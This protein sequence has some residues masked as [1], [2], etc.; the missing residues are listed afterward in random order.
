MNPQEEFGK[1]LEAD[2]EGKLDADGRQRLESLC[3]TR[4]ELR[5]R[6]DGE[7]EITR[8]LQQMGPSH[9]PDFLAAKVM[10]RLEDDAPSA[11]NIIDPGKDH[12]VDRVKAIL[13]RP[14]RQSRK[15]FIPLIQW[16]A[17]A[18][19]LTFIFIHGS[20]I[21]HEDSL[22][23]QI[24]APQGDPVG[25]RTQVDPVHSAADEAGGRINHLR[26][27][28]SGANALVAEQPADDAVRRDEFTEKADQKMIG[29]KGRIDSR[30]DV[31]H[32][33][34]VPMGPGEPKQQIP[35]VVPFME[36]SQV[37]NVSEDADPGVRET[38]TALSGAREPVKRLGRGT[39]GGD[40]TNEIV[41]TREQPE[42][43]E[44]RLM[45]AMETA[46]ETKPEPELGDA[47]HRTNEL[48]LYVFNFNVIPMAESK[49]EGQPDRSASLNKRKIPS[50]TGARE[51]SN[52]P[53]V[54]SF[55]GSGGGRKSNVKKSQPMKKPVAQAEA[56]THSRGSALQNI[57][58]LVSRHSGEIESIEM[59]VEKARKVWQLDL[60]MTV[61]NLAALVADL[62]KQGVPPRPAFRV[63]LESGSEEKTRNEMQNTENNEYMLIQGL[64]GGPILKSS[65]SIR[66]ISRKSLA[67]RGRFPAGQSLKLRIYVDHP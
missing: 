2:W 31:P 36:E 18:A 64:S 60:A 66:D 32:K 63:D 7:E 37:V 34:P 19:V 35:P 16:G 12:P 4:P 5:N 15:H 55:V 49:Y 30:A 14:V 67:E 10:E 51:R 3:R 59:V 65:E 44:V 57:R 33:R 47:P 52:P 9:A 39:E 53:L 46:G 42:K 43:K 58:E 50:I 27:P 20:S 23:S 6:L 24:A 40:D 61:G 21:I 8:L 38:L 28:D 62:E 22:Q 54:N 48:T 56:G 11:V 13:A 29:V 41:S 17:A 26:A 25:Y 1:L 45:A